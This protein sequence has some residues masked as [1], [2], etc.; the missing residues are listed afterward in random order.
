MQMNLNACVVR[1]KNCTAGTSRLTRRPVCRKAPCT[2][3]AFWRRIIRA[4]VTFRHRARF[5]PRVRHLPTWRVRPPST[6]T[7]TRNRLWLAG[8]YRPRSNLRTCASKS[9]CCATRKLFEQFQTSKKPT[10]KWKIWNARKII[11]CEFVPFETEKRQTIPRKRILSSTRRAKKRYSFCTEMY[12]RLLQKTFINFVLSTGSRGQTIGY[13][14]TSDN[15]GRRFRYRYVYMGLH[16]M[17]HTNRN[18]RVHEVF[19]T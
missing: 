2:D 12:N 13:G 10:S 19:N 16:S 7:R 11:P 14:Q 17:M 3:S 9:T 6:L 15:L 1:G 8:A 18:L 4:T 5:R